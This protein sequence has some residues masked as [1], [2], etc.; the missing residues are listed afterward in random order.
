MPRCIVPSLL[1]WVILGRKALNWSLRSVARRVRR[2]VTSG[3]CLFNPAGLLCG[4]PRC[5]RATGGLRRYFEVL[6]SRQ[7]V[8]SNRFLLM[9]RSVLFIGNPVGLK[10]FKYKGKIRLHIRHLGIIHLISSSELDQQEG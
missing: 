4:R 2:R 8:D 9:L 7:V 5:E 10:T 1:L 6:I 3:L